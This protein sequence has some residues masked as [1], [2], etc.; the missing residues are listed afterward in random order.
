MAS[1][2]DLY[3]I[4]NS[5]LQNVDLRAFFFS[6]RNEYWM[7]SINKN[8]WNTRKMLQQNWIMNKL[9]NFTSQIY[10]SWWDVK[11]GMF[12][13]CIF[14]WRWMKKLNPFIDF[15]HFAQKKPDL[16]CI[17]LF[18]FSSEAMVD[19]SYSNFAEDTMLSLISDHC[20]QKTYF[21]FSSNI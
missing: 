7:S 4:F 6:C 2:Y 8:A 3:F 15:A 1:I 12:L 16:Y 17:F 11:E 10:E 21:L 18:V 19:V 14:R 13:I 20:L 9:I 5:H